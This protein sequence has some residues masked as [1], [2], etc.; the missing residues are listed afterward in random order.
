MWQTVQSLTLT[1]AHATDVGNGFQR[2]TLWRR[3]SL[4]VDLK[5][6]EHN[7]DIVQ[8]VPSTCKSVMLRVRCVCRSKAKMTDG[9]QVAHYGL[10]Q[11]TELV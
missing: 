7:E 9:K 4:R 3:K 8:P 2:N 10:Q 6:E 11:I 5:S 1:P